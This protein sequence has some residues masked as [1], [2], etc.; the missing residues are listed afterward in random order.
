MWDSSISVGNDE[1][2]VVARWFMVVSGGGVVN[3]LF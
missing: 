2:P 1:I 3:I